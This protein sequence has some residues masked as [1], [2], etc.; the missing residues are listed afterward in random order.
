MEHRSTQRE[1]PLAGVRVVEMAGIGPGPHAA[2]VLADL[3]ADVVRVERPGPVAGVGDG[4]VTLR[5]RRWVRANLKDP[6]QLEMVLALV[7]HADV[8]IEGYRPGVAERL[9]IGPD[10]CLA[11]N[12]RLVYGRMTGWGQDGPLAPRAGHDLTY[13]ALT[14][15]LHA[16]GRPGVPPAPPMNLVADNGGGSMVLLVGLLSA[17][18]ERERSS[19]GQVVD[20]AMV[21]GVSLLAQLVHAMR[22]VGA[23]SGSPGENVLDG[24]APFYD[25]YTCADGRFLAVAPL[26]P[27]FYAEMLA[28]LGL[29]GADLPSQYDRAG[30]PRLRQAFADVIVTRTRDEWADVFADTDACVTPVLTWDE[31][32]ASPHL[33]ARATLVEVDGV[34]QAAPAPRFSRTP[35]AVTASVRIGDDTAAVVS[36]WGATPASG[37]AGAPQS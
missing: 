37:W 26:E 14:G 30:W 4:D 22:G 9:G 3:G 12:P 7:E 6:A 36:D 16:M 32:A 11:R 23:W 24:G 18:L 35:A 15:A 13:L 27:P 20:A 29:S 1:G 10:V 31:A 34:R 33:M 8:L 2:M 17:L 28:G 25:C 19:L 5:G 21:D